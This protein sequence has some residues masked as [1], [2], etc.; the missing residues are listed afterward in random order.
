MIKKFC[1]LIP[2][3]SSKLIFGLDQTLWNTSVEYN[4][5]MKLYDIREKIHPETGYI[6]QEFQ[7]KG[8]SLNIASQNSD[9]EKCK[10]LLNILFP[11]I[12]FDKIIINSQSGYKNTHVTD[13]HTPNSVKQFVL[14]DDNLDIL[15]MQKRLHPG[16]LCISSYPQLNFDILSS[17]Y[18]SITG[19]ILKNNSKK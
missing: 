11:D 9:K 8:Y 16:S 13:I 2:R 17:T 15:N 12:K 19:T 10:Y 4:K 1:K 5:N 6:L 14:F 7:N 18:L 3:N